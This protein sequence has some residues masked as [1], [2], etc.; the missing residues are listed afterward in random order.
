M[1]DNPELYESLVNTA[2]SMGDHNEFAEII[3]RGKY[4]KQLSVKGSKTLSKKI[5]IVLFQIIRNLPAVIL[6][7]AMAQY[8][9]N[10]QK[11]IQNFRLL[12][13]FYWP[14]VFIHHKLDIVSHLII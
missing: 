7:N 6:P 5:F 9:W 3:Q 13:V 1:E 11:P 4:K 12:D 10:H 8:Q 2:I 14:L